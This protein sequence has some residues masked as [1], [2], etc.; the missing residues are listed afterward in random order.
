M[1]IRT[2]LAHLNGGDGDVAVLNAAYAVARRFEAHIDVLAVQPAA[3][4]AAA[5]LT[6][7][8]FLSLG[9]HIIQN[10]EQMARE[11][12]RRALHS[13]RDWKALIDAEKPRFPGV[14][15]WHLVEGDPDAVL[16]RFGQVADLVVIGGAEADQTSRV[17]AAAEAALFGTARGVLLVPSG[18][19]LDLAKPMI[20]AWNGSIEATRALAAALPL[21]RLAP[22]VIVF[23][24]GPSLPAS[25]PVDR[26]AAYLER[27]GVVAESV[28]HDSE[29]SNVANE[30]LQ[31]ATGVGAGLVVLG[32]FTHGR[33]RQ[34]LLGGVTRNM[35]ANVS[36]PILMAH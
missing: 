8:M 13:F 15:A 7:G 3:G 28:H 10:V 17:P 26:V 24:A 6:H 29:G 27:H 19:V 2:I 23:A 18:T 34:M 9:G 32:A 31:L 30:L 16:V 33:M 20:V 12:I 5:V 21:L 35:L 4:T 36:I 14:V 1:T 22:R 11:G 25:A